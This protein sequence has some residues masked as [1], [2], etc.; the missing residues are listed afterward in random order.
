[1]HTAIDATQPHFEVFRVTL[2][3]RLRD[4]KG[5]DE[6][7]FGLLMGPLGAKLVGRLLPADSFALM[8]AVLAARG[9]HITEE[10]P[11]PA[12]ATP[13]AARAP[14]ALQLHRQQVLSR[15][16]LFLS[17]ILVHGS[18]KLLGSRSW[19]LPRSMRSLCLAQYVYCLSR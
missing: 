12:A 11:Q 5:G 17:G 8:Q 3:G 18:H 9:I 13:A 7:R 4:V 10:R 19:H 6:A 16:L 1:M 14:A 2:P 15:L